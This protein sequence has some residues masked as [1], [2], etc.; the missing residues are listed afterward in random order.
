MYL[1]SKKNSSITS[2]KLV[3]HTNFSPSRGVGGVHF[4]HSRQNGSKSISFGQKRLKKFLRCWV[5]HI[6]RVLA[7]Q[8]LGGGCKISIPETSSSHTLWGDLASKQPT[9]FGGGGRGKRGENQPTTPAGRAFW[10]GSSAFACSGFA[11][12]RETRKYN[13]L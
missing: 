13:S 8:T 10:A 2:P 1:Q 3:H 11:P 9:T 6:W 12:V 4:I 7:D 5:G